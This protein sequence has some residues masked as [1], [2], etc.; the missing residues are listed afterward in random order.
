[1]SDKY[2]TMSFCTRDY[3]DI[4]TG[5]VNEYVLFEDIAEFLRIVMRN[6]YQCKVWF[7]SLTYVIEFQEREELSG[8]SLEWLG[9]GEFIERY[10]RDGE[11]ER[12]EE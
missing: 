3:V 6:G 7:D 12:P 2:N 11:A 10:P 4:K 1:M 5:D 8:V 9:E